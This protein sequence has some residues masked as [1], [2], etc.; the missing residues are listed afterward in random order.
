[1]ARRSGRRG[2]QPTDITV[3]SVTYNSGHV[4]PGMLASVPT[5][6]P[7][8]LVDNASRDGAP[9]PP[10]GR[11]VRVIRSETN[12]GFGWACNAGAAIAQTPY[13]LFLNPDA[14]LTPDCLSLLL[15]AAATYPAASAFN[16]RIQDHTGQ[17]F[18]RRAT[19]LRG[20]KGRIRTTPVQD[21]AVPV[22]SGAALFVS[23]A[24]FD[25]VGG[26][27]ERI[28]LYAEDDDL[29]VRLQQQIGPLMLIYDAVVVHEPGTST[30][31]S[32]AV[33]AFKQ[34]NLARATVYTMHKHGRRL[35]FQ[36]CLL[37]AL[38]RF[39]KPQTYKSAAA[40]AAARAYLHGIWSAR[41]DRGRYCP[42]R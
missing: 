37:Q 28:F 11:D 39:L 9:I 16:P 42:D 40:S 31:P 1:M 20:N 13:L 35:A 33:T 17:M 36:Q 34:H 14:R 30:Q 27:D 22:L 8:V 10:P 19:R 2:L 25:A 38:R 6:T 23:K 12:H 32:P 21:M 7:V 5:E 26:F 29:S 3:I 24:H 41:K 4:L 18:F 15:T